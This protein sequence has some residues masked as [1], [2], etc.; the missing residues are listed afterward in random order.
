MTVVRHFV[1]EEQYLLPLV[2]ERLEDGG[3]LS[4]AAFDEHRRVEDELRR[5]EDLEHSTT[6]ARP[7]LADIE[8]ALRRHIAGQD[9]DVFPALRAGCDPGELHHLAGEILGSEQLAPT[10][11]RLVRAD[12]ARVNKLLSLVAGYVDQV[13][14]AYTHRGVEEPGGHADSRDIDG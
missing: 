11:P 10:R 2:R 12:S 14:D 1:A 6:A 13:R 3:A 5:L 8:A 7:V 9:A 4:E